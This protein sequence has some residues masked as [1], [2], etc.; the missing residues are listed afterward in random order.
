[1]EKYVAR[2]GDLSRFDAFMDYSV[3]FYT[4]DLQHYVDMFQTDDVSHFL[5]QWKGNSGSQW[6]SLIFLVPKS[7]YVIELVSQMKPSGSAVLP[8]MEQRMSDDHCSK[9]SSYKDNPTKTLEISSINRAAS[10]MKTIDDVH[11]NLYKASTTLSIDGEV[12]RRCFSFTSQ[13]DEDICFTGRAADAE[14]DAIF[15]VADHEAMLWAVH[16]S[17]LGNNPSSTKDKYT[18]SHYAQPISA[19]G[20]R[21]L[22]KHFTSNNPYPITKDTRLAY[23][24]EQSYIIDPTGFCVQPIGNANWPNCG[25]D[26]EAE[27]EV[28]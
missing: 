14:N 7:S 9:F 5:G 4:H 28:V 21:A 16:A 2:L 24:C 23:A 15:S 13:L 27:A 12:T 20:L 1:M 25:W 26:E 10:D 6:Y 18:D 11:T 17:T 19:S 3:T 22:K 8:E